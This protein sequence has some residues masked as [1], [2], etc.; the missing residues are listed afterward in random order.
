MNNVYH[1]L[2]SEFESGQS[3][4]GTEILATIMNTIKVSVAKVEK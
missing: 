3:Y 4:K 2:K 1:S